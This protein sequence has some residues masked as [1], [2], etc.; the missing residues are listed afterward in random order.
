MSS[1]LPIVA[2]ASSIQLFRFVQKCHQIVGIYPSHPN[3]R[4]CSINPRNTIFLIASIQYAITTIA[5]FAFEANSMFDYGFG[6]FLLICILNITVNYLTFIW[7]L[8]NMLDFIEM[9]EEFIEKSKYHL[10]IVCIESYHAFSR[11]T[12]TQSAADYKELCGKME[13]FNKVLCVVISSSIVFCMVTPLPYSF[14]RYYMYDMGEKSFYLFAPA[15][16]VFFIYTIRY[17][18]RSNVSN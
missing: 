1:G 10:E 17:K 2:M 15:W 14:V 16:F 8:E 7:Q 3:Q 12:G 13:L 18:T 6:F 5:F 11:L 4:R 9:C